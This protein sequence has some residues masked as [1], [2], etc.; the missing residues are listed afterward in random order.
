MDEVLWQRLGMF[1]S[2]D[3]PVEDHHLFIEI[4]RDSIY[5]GQDVKRFDV[6]NVSLSGRRM[7][8]SFVFSTLE[9]FS[10]SHPPLEGPS[11]VCSNRR[12][13]IIHG[14]SQNA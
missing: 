10:R 4:I 2:V 14:T 12:S 8:E 6:I 9:R 3:F 7:A 13:G 1:G 11:L 5:P